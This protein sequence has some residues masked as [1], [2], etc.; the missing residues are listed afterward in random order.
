MGDW[1]DFPLPDGSYS[2][3]TR[4]WTSQDVCN[5]LPTFAEAQGTRSRVKYVTAPGLRSFAGVGDGPHRGSRDVEGKLFVVSGST[6][7]QVAT[8]GTETSR[9]T[10]P[11]TSR[12]S[13]THNQIA[14]G[15]ELVIATGSNSYVWD[16]VAETLTATGVPLLFVDFINQMIVGMDVGRR[17]WRYSG[18]A[19]A[20]TWNA[21]DNESAESSPDRLVG[22]IVSQ[23]EV[24][25][26]GERTIEVWSNSPTDNTSFQRSTV[27]EK[28]CANGN[29]V[30]RLD[31]TVYFVGNDLIPYRLQGYTPVPIASKAISAQLALG[32]PAKLFANTWED[33]GYV[34]YYLTA[35]DGRT[36][37]YD[38]TCQKWHRRES[39]G[40]DRWRINTL[41]KW[42][43]AWYAG[44]YSSGILY[45]LEW[46]YVYEGADIFQRMIRSGV[47]H[48]DGNPA[49]IHALK[50]L[51]N[52]G[53]APSEP[54]SVFAMSVT[55]DI[56]DGIV[57]DTKAGSYTAAGGIAPYTYAVT[58]GAFP[59]GLLLA[60]D[61]SYSGTLTA[62]GPFAWTVTATDTDDTPATV[63]DAMAVTD[64]VSIDTQWRYKVIPIT[65]DTDYSPVAY[66]DSAWLE[67]G[68]PFGDITFF[69]GVGTAA[70]AFDARFPTEVT[71]FT[72]QGYVYLWMR[73]TVTASA[74]VAVAA[75]LKIVYDGPI[76]V[77]LNGAVIHSDS[78][79]PPTSSP[80][81][82][83]VSIP[84]LALLDGEN[85]IAIKANEFYEGAPPEDGAYYIAALLDIVP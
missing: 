58:D 56:T 32:N 82:A 22:L 48:G 73:C 9:G 18:L 11:G 51:V 4:P 24:L 60:A 46:G 26:F 37:G 78:T 85:V 8:D 80:M 1:R 40:L 67:G 62:A 36:W 42:N 75:L 33:R 71:T 7:Y 79:S 81:T 3:E 5:Y 25:L 84:S 15:N 70:H 68:Q 16:T 10:I 14:G 55:G 38:V 63:N 39:F 20:K 57:G 30:C 83:S 69:P 23:G 43:G 29:T 34:C 52:T 72:D 64:L 41:V 53:A 77:Y 2:D 6:L 12:V 76:S 27:I 19:D 54:F 21:L 50:V 28:G 65:D 31:N 35:Q 66:D 47:M 59:A 17:F 45:R 49:L 74:D 13:M 44:D 61:G